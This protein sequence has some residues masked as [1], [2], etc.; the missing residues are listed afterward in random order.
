[1]ETGFIRWR[2]KI[3]D[4]GG[5]LGERVETGVGEMVSQELSLGHSKF[6]FA[7]AN[8]QAMSS[9]Q[10]QDILEILNMS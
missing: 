5:V 2:R 3:P 8:R 1:M 10:V 6:T 9:A 4:G 7:Q